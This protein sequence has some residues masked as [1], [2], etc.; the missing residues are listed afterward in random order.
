MKNKSVILWDF[1][2][3][4]M[5]SNEI[6]NLGFLEVLKDFPQEQVELLMVFH[7]RNG[8]LSRYVKFRYFF[9]DIRKEQIT[10][11]AIQ[12]WAEKF[13]KIMMNLLCDKSLLIA[14]TINFVRENYNTHKM[15]IVSGSDQKELQAICQNLDIS[16]YFQSIYGSPT[17]KNNLVENLIKEN[18]YIRGKCILI[19]DS[20]NDYDAAIH[21]GIDFM[22]YGNPTITTKTTYQ[23]F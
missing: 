2:G 19:G 12:T 7:K 1:D 10:E 5:N 13:S 17:P 6:R 11:I 4:L 22:G 8:G 20:I 14:Q 21:N 23:I 9:E 3:V 18:D 15:H 16:K